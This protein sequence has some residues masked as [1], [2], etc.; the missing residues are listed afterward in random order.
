MAASILGF[1][2]DC[3]GADAAR[4]KAAETIPVPIL[5]YR[6][7]CP[8]EASG[9]ALVNRCPLPLP[10]VSGNVSPGLFWQ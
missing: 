4:C 7:G 3:G 9:K 8:Q 6:L 1:N 10:A 2:V 5:A